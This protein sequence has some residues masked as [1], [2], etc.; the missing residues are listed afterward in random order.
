MRLAEAAVDRSGDVRER[1][2]LAMRAAELAETAAHDLPRAA[3]LARRA[4]EAVPGYAP[5]AH[6]LERL[7]A[8]LGQ[9]GELVK[10]V[11]VG[12]ST[13]A[14]ERSPSGASGA[15]RDAARETSARFERVG[16]LYEERL[17][18]PGKALALYGEWAELGERRPAALRALLRAAEK[19][20]DALVAAEAALKLGTEIPELPA[21]ARFAWC[22]RAATIY[23][24]RAAADDEAVRA[25]EAALALDPGSRPALAGL[26]RAH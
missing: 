8:T 3:A 23:E 19:A 1:A 15:A 2:A 13:G 6:V 12:A 11:E 9:W 20:G 17:Q 7:Y 25:Y 18:D 14:G 24:E 21:D 4:L 10:V 22:Y 5:A 26:A 16:A